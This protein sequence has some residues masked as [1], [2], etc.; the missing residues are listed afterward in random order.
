MLLSACSGGNQDADKEKSAEK[1]EVKSEETSEEKEEQDK[2]ESDKKEEEEE[3]EESKE[4]AKEEKDEEEQVDAENQNTVIDGMG[5]TVTIPENPQRVLALNSA[6]ME[7]FFVLGFVPVGKVENYK[8]RE[9]GMALPSVGNPNQINIEKVYE[10]K[11]D[12]IIAHTRFHSALVEDLEA[13]GAVVYF[14]NPE[15]A[16]SED[17]EPWQLVLA[18]SMGKEQVW[19]DHEKSLDDLGKKLGDEIRAIKDIKTGVMIDVSSE[20]IRAAQRASGFG[21]MLSRLGIENIIPDDMP[22]AGKKSWVKYDI[23]KIIEADPD[24]VLLMPKT[25]DKEEN[26]AALKAFCQDPKWSSLKAVEN[27]TVFMLPF[28]VNPNRSSFEG[29]LEKTAEAIKKGLKK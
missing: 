20:G 22:D 17:G 8:I 2:E 4:E 23:E 15:Q 19:L 29:M 10:L 25:K 26:K 11:P 24:I 9:E 21:I 6:M 3:K 13:T 27:K 16:I 1:E 28:A 14:M 12:F 7:S 18:R 5:R